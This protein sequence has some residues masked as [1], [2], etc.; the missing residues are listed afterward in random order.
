MGQN[1]DGTGRD[2]FHIWM[3]QWHDSDERP[4]DVGHGTRQA[5]LSGCKALKPP[6]G[7]AS[8]FDF[9]SH[10][11]DSSPFF[12]HLFRAPFYPF[13]PIVYAMLC[14][15][16]MLALLIVRPGFTWPG[17]LIVALGIPV[18]GMFRLM[19]GRDEAQARAGS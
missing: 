7:S 6:W 3:R 4:A 19:G 12:G 16:L 9:A 1:I 10:L 2:G 11:V 5:V 13:L 8:C 17:L 18:Y 14:I 15:S